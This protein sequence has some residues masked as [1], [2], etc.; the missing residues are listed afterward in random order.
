MTLPTRVVNATLKQITHVLCR[1]DGQQLTR[2]P[3]QG[4]LIVAANH[5]NFLEI[6]IMYTHL[7][8][9][10]VTGFAKAESWDNPAK[11]FLFDLWDAIPLERGEPDLA[12]LRR[13]LQVLKEGGILAVA[14]EGTRSGHGKLQRAHAGLAWLALR[15]QAPVMPV[16]YHG[17]EQ[18][19]ENFRKLRRTDFHVNVG[20][21][22]HIRAQ[23]SPVTQAVRQQMTDEVMYQI[24]ALLPPKYR[25]AYAD[26][27]AA[28][29]TYLRFPSGATSNLHR[30]ARYRS[31]GSKP[32]HP[33]DNARGS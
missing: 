2:I 8:P 33:L 27:T 7:Q 11:R 12:A 15:S 31:S 10:P 21:W 29:E 6:P 28:T 4:P 26:L 30:A 18:F 13:A 5:V 19:W 1:I 17:G 23:D 24:A 9:R 32:A 14:P 3:E 22:F 20:Q 16:A 25:G